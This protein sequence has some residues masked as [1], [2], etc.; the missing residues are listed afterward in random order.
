MGDLP[1]ENN[2]NVNADET[3]DNNLNEETDSR[4]KLKGIIVDMMNELTVTYP[5]L[6]EDLDSDIKNVINDTDKEDKSI[7]A[8]EKYCETVFP[9]R[10]FDILY[11]NEDIF[12]K[13]DINTTFLPNIDFSKLWKENITENTKESLWKYLQ[14]ILFTIVSNI[15]D[16]SSFGDTAKLFEAIN[17]DEFKKK[18]EETVSEMQKMFT[19]NL[20]K[21]TAD[22]TPES[23]SEK[24]QGFPG[25]GNLPDPSKLQ[26]HISEMMNG[27]LGNLA[28]EIAEETANDMDIDM[29]N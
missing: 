18:L 29:N 25:M 9:E 26:D 11:K 3:T 19:E 28:K 17:H 16:Q 23:S 5:E 24:K 22:G 7:I 12:V 14:V 2:A 13:D 10:F 8:I 15:K 6:S 20:E 4:V 21:E 1:E 27:K